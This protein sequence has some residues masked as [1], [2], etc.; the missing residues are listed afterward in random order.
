MVV[1]FYLLSLGFSVS[2]LQTPADQ[3]GISADFSKDT[4]FDNIKGYK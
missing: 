4:F 1:Q 2:A 3:T